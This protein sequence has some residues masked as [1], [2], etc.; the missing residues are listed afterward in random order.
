MEGRVSNPPQIHLRTHAKV[1]V[2]L[3]CTLWLSETPVENLSFWLRH[4]APLSCFCVSLLGCTP[5]SCT[6][7]TEAARPP[8]VTESAKQVE[9]ADEYAG[10]EP[11][12]PL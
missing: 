8:K 2:P 3:E 11:R 10:R 7:S 4:R 1:C 6:P 9:A 5:P 12:V